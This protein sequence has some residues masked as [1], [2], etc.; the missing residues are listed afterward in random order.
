MREYARLYLEICKKCGKAYQ[1]TRGHQ[2]VCPECRKEIS[3][4]WA[5]EWQRMHPEQC[6]KWRHLHPEVSH[7]EHAK[8]RELGFTP[9]N[10]PFEGCV[11]H[12]ID[13]DHVVYIPEEVHQSIPHSVFT[14]WGMKEIN[15][16]AMGWAR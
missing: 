8:R 1:P 15:A 12:H 2:K 14:G 16:L 10:K 3:S 13:K 11:G 7:R 4:T 9:L 6:S 5:R